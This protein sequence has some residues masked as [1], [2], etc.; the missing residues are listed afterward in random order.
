MYARGNVVRG[1]GQVADAGP[2]G[3][4]GNEWLVRG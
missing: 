4:T 1:L 3:N 2:G